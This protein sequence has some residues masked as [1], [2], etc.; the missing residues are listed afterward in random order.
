[1]ESLLDD[2][3]TCLFE[4]Q[5]RFS[6]S[7]NSSSGENLVGIKVVNIG[8]NRHS[9]SSTVKV[10]DTVGVYR[11]FFQAPTLQV[12]HPLFKSSTHSST[13]MK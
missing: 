7:R 9:E 10:V 13:F 3:S 12:F 5:S 11:Y 4:Y 8:G 6:M 2:L 1:M